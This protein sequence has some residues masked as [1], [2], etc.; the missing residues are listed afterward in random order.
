MPTLYSLSLSEAPY[1]RRGVNLLAKTVASPWY[2]GYNEEVAI[3][4]KGAFTLAAPN[5]FY[6]WADKNGLRVSKGETLDSELSSEL[7]RFNAY[8]L[9]MNWQLNRQIN[10]QP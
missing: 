7:G 5:V 8:K 3:S 4:E 10:R 1:Y 9:I 6:P 2:F